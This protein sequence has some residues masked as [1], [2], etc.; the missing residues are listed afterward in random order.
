MNNEK[1][2]SKL[3]EIKDL[4]NRMGEDVAPLT[5]GIDVDYVNNTVAYN[6]RHQHA[7]DTSLENN[8]TYTEEYG[9]GIKVWSIFQRKGDTTFDGNP[10]LYALKNEKGW[11]F[12]REVDKINVMEQFER[13]AWKF[14]SLYKIGF[15]ILIPSGNPLNRLIGDT[16]SRVCGNVTIVDDVLTKITTEEVLDLVM[17][18]GSPFKKFYGE[19]LVS[20]LKELNIYLDKMN[21]ERGGYFTRHFVKSPDMRNVL[22]K[23]LR[24]SDDGLAKYAKAID[25]QDVL[26]I[27]DTISRGQT[28]KE[29][30]DI[31]RESYSPNSITVLTLFSKVK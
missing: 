19:N 26:L 2:I 31:L 8:P 18:V 24:L 10:L 30:C 29:A 25:G 27:D 5:E 17:E 16:I 20:A 21:K 4:M 3:T 13:I 22:T 23:T 1:F 12:R 11:K 6:P 15:T 7:V 14:S 9:D 28:I